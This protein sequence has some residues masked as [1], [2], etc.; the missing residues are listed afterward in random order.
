MDALLHHGHWPVIGK[1]PVDEF[2]TPEYK[3]ATAPG[4]YVVEDAR[5]EVIRDATPKDLALLPFRTVV[6]PIRLQHA[7]EALHGAREWQPG[8]DALRA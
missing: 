3:V 7:F 4:I 8:Y 6:A 2:R 5:G 1:A